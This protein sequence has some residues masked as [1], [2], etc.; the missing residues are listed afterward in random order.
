MVKDIGSLIFQTMK[1]VTRLTK[2][3]RCKYLTYIV[4]RHPQTGMVTKYTGWLGWEKKSDIEPWLRKRLLIFDVTMEAVLKVVPT[5]S[6]S[7]IKGTSLEVVN[8]P[9]G[10]MWGGLA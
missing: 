3:R 5:V 1:Q 2:N 6:R 8:F 4:V 10:R 9:L 7:G